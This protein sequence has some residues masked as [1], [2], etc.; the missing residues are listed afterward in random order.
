MEDGKRR[1]QEEY[2]WS[3]DVDWK[4]NSNLKEQNH[5]FALPGETMLIE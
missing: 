3:I 2:M 4:I 1:K 5:L